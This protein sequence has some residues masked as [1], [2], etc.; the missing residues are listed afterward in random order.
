HLANTHFQMGQ[1]RTAENLYQQ[2]LKIA[3]TENEKGRGWNCLAFLYL[4]KRDFSAAE[5]A[6]KEVLKYNQEDGWA[7][8]LAAAEKGDTI[9][10]KQLETNIL[11]LTKKN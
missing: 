11:P 8:F 6:A 9:R 4:K 7:E 2:Y 5:K 10:A 3:P 1:Y